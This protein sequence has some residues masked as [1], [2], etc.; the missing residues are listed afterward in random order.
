[1]TRP[2][3]SH[4]RRLFLAFARFRLVLAPRCRLGQRNLQPLDRGLRENDMVVAQ[5]VIGMNR[6]AFHQFRPWQIPRAQFEI[7]V[8]V[9]GD[10]HQQRGLLDLQFVE[11]LAK[12][13]R[14]YFLHVERI[15]DRDLAIGQLRGQRR[16]QCS[17]QLLPREGVVVGA[18]LR[19]MHRTA[20]PPQGRADRSDTGAP[21][22]FLLPQFLAGTGNPPTI[23]G[24][25]CSRPLPSAVV[26]HRLPEQVLVHRA[27]HLI[28]EIHR[29][30]LGA[31]QVV[32]IDSC[33]CSLS[34]ATS[35]WQLAS[36]D[37]PLATWYPVPGS[38]LSSLLSSLPSRDRPSPPLRIRTALAVAS[39]RA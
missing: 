28:G 35:Y 9:L 14:L 11:R 12:R 20:V 16:P 38:S 18:W 29:A 15:H 3:P 27:K 19:S 10:F 5:Q 26:L 34:I 23:L 21:R 30:D 32:D 2:S 13:L 8:S 36:S 6:I 37:L 39:S 31:V 4:P 22:A 25:V 24:R 7:A 17:Q 33:H 1:M